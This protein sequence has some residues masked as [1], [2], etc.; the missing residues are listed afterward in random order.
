MCIP[1]GMSALRNAVRALGRRPGV[2][3]LAASSLTVA[4][5]LSTVAFSILD[6]IFFRDLPVRDPASL[7]WIGAYDAQGRFDVV[8][9]RE[10]ELIRNRTRLVT[11]VLAQSRRGPKVRLPDRDDFPITAGVSENFFDLLGVPA[12]RGDV[13]HTGADREGVVVISNRYWN[14]KLG[15]DP[16]ILGRALIVRNRPLR[17]IGVLPPFFTGPARGIAVDLFVPPRT[18][19]DTLRMD[20]PANVKYG[21]YELIARL[22]P[23]ATLEQVKRE[24]APIF[25]EAG[26][27]GASRGAGR[28]PFV[29]PLTG[30]GLAGLAGNGVFVALMTLLVVIAAMNIACLRLVDNEIRR[31]DTAVRLAIGA[32]RLAL[33][34]EHVLETL[35]LIALGATGGVLLAAWLVELAPGML[36]GHRSYVDYG[37]RMDW[38]TFAF[39]AAAVATTSLIAALLPVRDAWR[40]G[41]APALHA[42]TALA[43]SRWLTALVVA[44]IAFVTAATFSAAALWRTLQNVSAIRPAMDPGRR[45]LLVTGYWENKTDPR[46]ASLLAESLGAL[47]G[48]ERVAHARRALLSGSGGGAAVTVDVPNQ[49]KFSY[50]YDQVSESYFAV[51]GARVTRGRAFTAADSPDATPVIMINEA[52]ARRFFPGGEPLGAWLA[53]EGRERQIVGVVEDGPANHL[54]E[55]IEPYLYLPFAQF[56]SSEVTLFVETAREPSRMAGSVRNYLRSSNPAFTITGLATMKQHMNHARQSE[57]ITAAASGLL[58]GAALL[59]AAAG[60]FGVT[61]RAVSRR[62]REFG[63]RVALGASPAALRRNV[64]AGAARNLAM[65]APL[66]WML[67]WYG[68][69][70]L[71]QFVYGDDALGPA[72]WLAATLVVAVACVAAFV[73]AQWAARVDAAVALRDE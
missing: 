48:V 73:P 69:R 65:G 55:K 19:F 53:V 25:R 56:P 22:R 50:H 37:I 7:L 46:A 10:Y 4:I 13:F 28:K 16:E 23:G 24:L 58:A 71:R 68:R 18:F 1:A 31:R 41:V 59:L 20:S 9:W 33:V 38:R 66:G 2:T 52:L 12:A 63:I 30:P 6:A 62:M 45:L 21:D 5:G 54:K 67:A 43:G 72:V 14:N 8:T 44:Q 36:F 51:T 35:L 47:P 11:G 29:E 17:V 42:G 26:K 40:H 70:F 34:R 61:L 3:I 39:A 27:Q 57:R 60:L 32:G 15:G 64:L 49:G